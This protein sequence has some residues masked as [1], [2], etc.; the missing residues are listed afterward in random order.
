MWKAFLLIPRKIRKLVCKVVRDLCL[1]LYDDFQFKYISLPRVVFALS[2][3]AVMTSWIAEQFFG[4]KFPNFSSLVTW[5]IACAGA[6]AA[7]KYSDK[8]RTYP[9]EVDPSKDTREQP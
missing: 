6:Y 8:D 9:K 3:V 1:T 4:Y 7:K 5:C 2:V